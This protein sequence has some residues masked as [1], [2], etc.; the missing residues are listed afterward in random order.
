MLHAFCKKVI[1]E[2]DSQ[3]IGIA[4]IVSIITPWWLCVVQDIMICCSGFVCPFNTCQLLLHFEDVCDAILVLRS[5]GALNL[6]LGKY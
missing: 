2:F 4:Q 5:L 6:D 1:E 3:C